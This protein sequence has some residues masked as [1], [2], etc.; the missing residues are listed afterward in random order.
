MCLRFLSKTDYDYGQFVG[1]FAKFVTARTIV[2]IG[3]HFGDTAINLIDAAKVTGGKYVG[4]DYWDGIGIYNKQTSKEEVEH[5]ILDN[6]FD[7]NIFKLRKVD[8]MSEDFFDI[9]K[10]DTGGI[11]DFAFIDGDHSYK[12]VKSD[13]EKVYPL[14]SEE[15]VIVFHDTYSHPGCRNFILDLYETY[16]DGTFDFINLP[17]GGAQNRFGLTLLVKRSYPL[18]KAGAFF[19]NHEKD[20]L[21]SEM[22]Y[23]REQIIYNKQRGL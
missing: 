20:G 15:G 12:G 3:V 22:V 1:S 7:S 10:E 13:F 18:Y 17:Y 11:I 8:T 4:Y 6:G 16:N 23:E 21:T 9:L 14:L 5:R 2:E 19:S